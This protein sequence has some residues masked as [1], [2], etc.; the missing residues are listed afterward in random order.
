MTSPRGV[1]ARSSL[2]GAVNATAGVAATLEAS[3]GFSSHISIAVDSRGDGVGGGGGDDDVHPRRRDA[4]CRV[5]PVRLAPVRAADSSAS[6]SAFPFAPVSASSAFSS[7]SRAHHPQ[8]AP[9]RAEQRDRAG[10]LRGDR[11]R[12]GFDS[13]A[14]HRVFSR[15]RGRRPRRVPDEGKGR[16]G[17]AT[18][19]GFNRRHANLPLDERREWG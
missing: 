1:T 13:I 6:S 16:T 9:A 4:E 15:R 18:D 10:I 3:F 12:R 8:I 17:R 14:V 2:P 5:P 19:D 7:S 11:R